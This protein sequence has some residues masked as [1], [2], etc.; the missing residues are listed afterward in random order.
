M[1]RLV[2]PALRTADPPEVGAGLPPELLEVPERREARRLDRWACAPLLDGWLR[3]LS[4]H[5]ALCRR[6]VGQLAA[7]FLRR[8]GHQRLGFARLGDYTRERLGLGA[9]EVQ[10]LARVATQLE[11][12][13]VVADAFESGALSW[14][15]VRL[16][17]RIATD[18]SAA[19]WVERAGTLTVRELAS[20]V[21]THQAPGPDPGDDD[22]IDG[23][24]VA[25]LRIACP[26]RVRG[27][28]RETVELARRMAGE[29]LAVWQAA[30]AVAGE[31]LSAP[32][33]RVPTA[34]AAVEP[35][36][37]SA[38]RALA[39]WVPAGT[40]PAE[41]VIGWEPVAGS[42]PADIARLATGCDSLDVR[43][44]D[45]RMRAALGA[46]AQSDWQLGRLL[47]LF[48][49]LRLER[50]LGFSSRSA[51][52][53]ERLGCSTRKARALIALERRG[54]TAPAVHAA[55]RAGRLSWL[56]A[57]TLLPVVSETTEIEWLARAEQV[58]MR[59]LADE[60]GW[61]LARRDGLV[62]I[63]PPPR[64]ADL[65]RVE[66]QLCSPGAWAPCD[67]DVSFSGPG[68]VVRLFRTAV[69]AFT[70]PAD[71]PWQGLDRLLRHVAGTWSRQ[72]RHRDPIFER[73]G[74]RCAV[75]ACTARRNMHDH[76]LLFRSR[77]GHNERDNR[78]TL[79]VWHHL[80]GIH[81]SD[82]GLIRAWGR[83]PDAVRWEVGVAAGRPP[84]LQ[85]FG[86]RYLAAP[87]GGASAR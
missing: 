43:T 52:V 81:G 59:R 69:A 54:F 39:G 42:I 15:H 38:P 61:A 22:T 29:E 6:V 78:I 12:L 72:P 55:Y 64:D 70:R 23:E 37:E 20:L 76:H 49:D 83:A 14:A 79:C 73:D 19:A 65:R 18:E 11:E 36:A 30:E 4:R 3:R 86:D 75:P 32:D 45:G 82:G 51:Y 28:W 71:A 46:M 1:L 34:E 48:H 24:P 77:G 35:A 84:L 56:R 21:R 50:V 31:G 17:G 62:P 41:S 27:A 26:R 33:R 5:D 58:T 40:T 2:H 13:P 57:T 10:E 74:W 63:A 53:R 44:L 16:L 66:R 9:R 47:R 85:T 60:V 67:S 25:R 7:A 80:H 8:R 68:S 87:G